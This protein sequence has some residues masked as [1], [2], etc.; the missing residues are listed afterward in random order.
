MM[1]QQGMMGAN[2][3]P[4][5]SQSH[6]STLIQASGNLAQ[7]AN[8]MHPMVLM[9]Q[10]AAVQQPPVATGMLQQQGMSIPQQPQQQQV[11]QGASTAPSGYDVAPGA[12]QIQQSHQAELVLQTQPMQQMQ[13]GVQHVQ[14]VPT[15]IPSVV[16]HMPATTMP[17][18][19]QQVPQIPQSM[20][21]V[22][23]PVQQVVWL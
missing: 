21:H 23:A 1:S 6:Q 15:S 8:A 2:P 7:Q 14:Q 3:A 22:Q 18:V 5:Q 11:L 4:A 20:S 9:A 10:S 17:S 13:P 16:Q 19:V 12:S